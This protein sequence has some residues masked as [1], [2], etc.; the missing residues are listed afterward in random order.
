MLVMHGMLAAFGPC[1]YHSDLVSPSTDGDEHAGHVVPAPTPGEPS[2][3]PCPYELLHAMYG[4][5]RAISTSIATGSLRAPITFKV[6][7][8]GIGPGWTLVTAFDPPPRSV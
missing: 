7:S 8:L 1:P 4:L 3:G 5:F 2:Q 6:L